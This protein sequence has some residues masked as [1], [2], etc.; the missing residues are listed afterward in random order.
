[1]VTVSR[2]AFVVLLF[3]SAECVG[4]QSLWNPGFKGYLAG[5]DSLNVGDLISVIID[6]NTKLSYSSSNVSDRTITINFQGAA[7]GN[8]L[9]FL[10]PG[11]SAGKSNLK[12]GEEIRLSTKLV[13]RVQKLDATGNAFVQGSRTLEVNGR[14]EMLTV[15]GWL[16]PAM[17]IDGR[18]VAF[19]NLADSNLVYSSTLLQR[20]PVLTQSDIT[21]ALAQAATGAAPP[22][23]AGTSAAAP[24]APNAPATASA[25]STPSASAQGTAGS[26]APGLQ[27]TEAKKRQLLLEYL[28]KMLDLIFSN[29]TP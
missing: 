8:P 29:G 3:F 1:M 12:G 16:D 27:I 22:A 2:L 21:Q 17:L 28:N 23:G 25:P 19:D 9:S 18:S 7:T 15:S 11:T 20:H 10:P 24:P 6:A 26:A 14:A 4:A 13:V 5:R